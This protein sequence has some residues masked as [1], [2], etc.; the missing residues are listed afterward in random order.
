[1]KLS[2]HFNA[3]IEASTPG[4]IRQERIEEARK[5][6]GLG[7]NGVSFIGN[8]L[9]VYERSLKALFEHDKSIRATYTEKGFETKVIGFLHPHFPSK[10]LLDESKSR[11]FFEE[12]NAVPMVNYSVFREI[13][14]IVLRSVASPHQLGPFTIYHFASHRQLIEAKTS[15]SPEHLW[16]RDTPEY[17]VE[18]AVNAHHSEKAEEIADR[19]YEKLELCLR[20]AIGFDTDRYEVGILNYLGW[21]HRRAY[22]FSSNGSMSSSH[23]NHGALEPIPLDDKYFTDTRVGL[24]RMW[25][26]LKTPHPSELE[27][28]LILAIEWAGQSYNELSPPSSFLKAAIALEILFT[29]NEKTL[30]SAS[31]LNQISEGVALILGEGADERLKIETELKRLYSM[32][33]AIAHAGKSE[34]V[35]EDLL[36]ILRIGRSAILTIM[37]THSLRDLRSIADIHAHLKRLKYS[38]ASI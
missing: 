36:S 22:I 14:G 19:L 2:E 20:F 9:H 21:R 8:D 32:R 16:I 17:L 18:V 26:M 12:L 38:C 27:R 33:S 6:F 34:I 25:E 13:H 3:I 29:Q 15:I 11:S 28:R 31:I 23:R 5:S 24:D 35:R 4:G 30:I 7:P 1:M 10:T 37:T